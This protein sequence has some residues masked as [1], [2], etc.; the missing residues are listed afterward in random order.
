VR[1]TANASRTGQYDLL[2]LLG[3]GGV[4]QVYTA[5]D[6]VLGRQVAIKTLR[7]QFGH[8][9]DFLT[10]FYSEAQRLGELNHPNITTLYALH[11]EGQEPFM[12]MEL[13]RGQ[14]L[15]VLLGRVHRLPLRE[16]LA[17][18]AQTMA[19]LTYA[20]RMGIV[21]RDVK[22]ANLM[23]SE[24]GL[25]KIM[26]FGIARVR[27]SQRMTRAGQMFG[28]LLYASPEQIRG[29][30]VDERSDLYSL[31]I[32]LYEM[33]AGTP[34]FEAENDHALMT[35][36]L[37]TSPPPLSGRVRGID[38]RVDAALMRALA[39]KPED[40]FA[41]V[42]EFGRAVGATAVRG[43][44]PDI[45]QQCFA[46]GLRAR[47]AAAT[48]LVTAQAEADATRFMVDDPSSAGP[49][50]RGTAR[51][52]RVATRAPSM[53]L[54][55]AL[56][57]AVAVV[58]LI[59]LGYVVLG[60]TGRTQSD[61]RQTRAESSQPNP[62]E[63]VPHVPR[64]ASADAV[65]EQSPAASPPSA[66]PGTPASVASIDRLT[67]GTPSIPPS[68]ASPANSPTAAKPPP[69]Q[70][71]PTLPAVA[72]PANLSTAAELPPSPAPLTTPAIA[73]LGNQRPAAEPASVPPVASP[74]PPGP[75]ATAPAETLPPSP[76][77][78]A[79]NSPA[80]QKADLRGTVSA[81]KSASTIRVDGQ[82][83]DL[84]G[85]ND[86]TSNQAGH[87]QAMINY[88]KP[89]QGAVECYRRAG[90]RYQCYANGADLGLMALR[91]GIARPSADAPSDYA[92]S[93]TS[94]H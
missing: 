60:P 21:H 82:W 84:Y 41:S 70:T 35:A 48:R 59:G 33:L 37:D 63:A 20:H 13:V 44:A 18:V 12:V 15:E 17:V 10:R 34:P 6:R 11:L 76:P 68:N 80:P 43:E 94:A 39:K 74:S 55:I 25:L 90:G 26:D 93:L 67:P 86:P 27:G 8:D 54:P 4:G 14:T 52:G 38:P 51:D 5:R 69:S 30:D 1:A 87:V 16:S 49:L 71:P 85:V 78:T 64:P 24:S 77:L 56:L 36:H 32:V 53:R 92:A 45:L 31:A 22:P 47:P 40:R 19:G 62:P 83:I 81:V 23:V 7:P 66:R 46:A 58:L 57:G 2:E 28:T 42:E 73:D 88:L 29:G 50:R 75:P 91:G 79:F 61:L 3:E 65:G 72:P 9:R 89:S